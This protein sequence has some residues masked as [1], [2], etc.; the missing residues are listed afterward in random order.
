MWNRHRPRLGLP[1]CSSATVPWGCCLGWYV[2]G[3]DRWR[4]PCFGPCIGPCIEQTGRGQR[5]MP[6]F[7]LIIPLWMEHIPLWSTVGRLDVWMLWDFEWS[8]STFFG[9][10]HGINSSWDWWFIM[11][12]QGIYFLG[13]QNGMYE[14]WWESR[15]LAVA[16]LLEI[17]R[18]MV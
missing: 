8:F 14:T 10:G 9:T 7:L 2:P 4:T 3:P 15:G 6:V 17:T 13:I 1:D 16:K 11:G 5:N 12:V 18:W